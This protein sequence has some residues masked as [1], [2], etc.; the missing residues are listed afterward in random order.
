MADGKTRPP[1]S[2]R[3]LG[4]SAPNAAGRLHA[5]TSTTDVARKISALPASI[6]HQSDA[7]ARAEGPA[8]SRAESSPAH[9]ASGA[10]K[11]KMTAGASKR[12]GVKPG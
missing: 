4:A 12:F 8:G 5:S 9:P 2:M 11:N 1:H 7:I 10:G 3:S 6:V